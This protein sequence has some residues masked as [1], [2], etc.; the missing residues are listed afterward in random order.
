MCLLVGLYYWMNMHMLMYGVRHLGV[1]TVVVEM[2]VEV[3]MQLHV[4]VGVG[5]VACLCWRYG[6][7]CYVWSNGRIC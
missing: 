7:D 6:L 1:V 5:V 4:D 2:E 3:E